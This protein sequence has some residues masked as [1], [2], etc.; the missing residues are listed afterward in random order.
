MDKPESSALSEVGQ[1]MQ[2]A[3]AQNASI[4]TLER[5]MSLYEHSQAIVARQQFNEAFARFQQEMPVV[6]KS[7]SAAFNT[8]NGRMEY[9]YASIDDVVAAV[10]RSVLHRFGLTYWFEQQQNGPSITITCHLCYLS[11]HSI[12]N[13][14]T[15]PVDTTGNKSALQQI[16]STVT[17]LKRQTLVGILGLACTDDDTDGYVPDMNGDSQPQTQS[18][19]PDKDFQR[20]L[21]EWRASIESG[22]QSAERI[23]RKINSKA[24]ATPQQIQQLK[25]IHIQPRG[26]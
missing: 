10:Q 23:I 25:A 4:D 22:Q 9:T 1:I 17:Y 3:I 24:P 8:K 20:H 11:G 5:V 26:H 13:T 21:P 7:K 12:A 18:H 6:K 2:S 14:A 16:G 19:Y 15:G